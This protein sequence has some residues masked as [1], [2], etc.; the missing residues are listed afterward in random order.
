MFNPLSKVSQVESGS[1]RI[2]SRA[3]A[4]SHGLPKPHSLVF[5]VC[6]GF[7]TEVEGQL[8]TCGPNPDY[9][10]PGLQGTA[11]QQ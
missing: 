5:L 11:V 8:L 10:T 6:L 9:L 4:L 3:Y 2:H 1:D 7:L